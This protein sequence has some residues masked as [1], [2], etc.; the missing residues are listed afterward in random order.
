MLLGIAFAVLVTRGL[1][2][3]DYGLFRY[4]MT[5]LALAMTVLQFGWPYSAARLL[6]LE[7]DRDAQ[8]EIVGACLILVLIGSFVGTILTLAGA[9]AAHACG[10]HL[11]RILIWVAPFLYVT[12]GQTMIGSIC[13]GLNRIPLLSYQQVLPYLLLLPITA[14]QVYLWHNYSLQAAIV[15]YVAVY[16]AVITF[17]FYRLG[18]VF[19]GWRSR[20]HAVV[21]ENRYTGFPMYIGGLFGVAS[22][23]VIA[24]WVAEF[25][26]PSRYGQYAL[27]LAVSSPLSVL[28]SSVGSV[29]F[30]SSSRSNSLPAKTLGFSFGFGGMLGL[31]YFVATESLLVRLFGSA[32]GPTVRMAQLMGIGGLLIGWGD[33][34][35][36]FLG[37]RGQGRGLGLVAVSTGTVGI[38]SAAILLPRWNAYGAIAA[39]VL[40]AGAYFAMMFAFYSHHTRRP[41]PCPIAN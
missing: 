15:A 14:A 13:Q 41:A 27:A 36:R 20:L 8:K 17:G 35:N 12:L 38:V 4:A 2:V 21:G 33:I 34:F 19:T 29:V 40:A 5:F 30:R 31:A 18:T 7:N 1:A 26:D 23:Q 37:A 24:M 28:I 3:A 22:A 9:A 11:P 32:Y 16:S 10:Y 25:V 6:A 39:S